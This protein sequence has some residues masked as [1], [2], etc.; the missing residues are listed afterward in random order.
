V[1]S[2]EQQAEELLMESQEREQRI[3]SILETALVGCLVVGCRGR[4]EVDDHSGHVRSDQFVYARP[5]RGNSL[6]QLHVG[7]G[8]GTRGWPISSAEIRVLR[9]QVAAGIRISVC[10]LAAG[11]ASLQN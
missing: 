4:S 10:R 7:G 5:G 11:L 8:L 6:V 2:R 3:R 9:R 1:N